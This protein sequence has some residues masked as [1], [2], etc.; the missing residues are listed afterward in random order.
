MLKKFPQLYY[1]LRLIKDLG[2]SA[3]KKFRFDQRKAKRMHPSLKFQV[4][5]L[6]RYEINSDNVENGVQFEPVNLSAFNKL[7]SA[8]PEGFDEWDFIDL[9]CGNG[10]AV[11]KAKE[12]GF[13]S[14]TGVDFAP[15][16]IVEAQSNFPF[17]S[18]HMTDVL[19]YSIDSKKAFVFLFNPF[20]KEVLSAVLENLSN[21]EGELYIAYVN[22]PF[23]ELF[24]SY[25]KV[26]EQSDPIGL[27]GA[28][29]YLYKK[30]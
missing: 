22:N 29:S 9:G 14:Y 17:A 16:L 7:I 10:A 25:E 3:Y 5:E 28:K 27:Y 1:R 21:K 6:K 26:Y 2:W 24:N 30:K 8:C 11:R 23:P 18:F 15:E 13:K 4:G 12:F 19:E 20:G